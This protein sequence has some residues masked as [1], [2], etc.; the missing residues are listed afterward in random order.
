MAQHYLDHAKA[1]LTSKCSNFKG[2][3]KESGIIR[4]FGDK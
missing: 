4:L 2:G 3:S 1:I